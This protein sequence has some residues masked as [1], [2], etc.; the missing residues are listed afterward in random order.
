MVTSLFEGGLQLSD[1]VWILMNVG[2]FY[3]FYFTVVTLTQY[4]IY[5]WF[6]KQVC[7]EQRIETVI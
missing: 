1:C 6:G 4:I 7:G 3:I 2:V 5:Y